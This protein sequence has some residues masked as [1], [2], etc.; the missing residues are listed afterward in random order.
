MKAKMSAASETWYTQAKGNVWLVLSTPTMTSRGKWRLF[1]LNVAS[2]SYMNSLTKRLA[3]SICS[4]EV[5]KMARNCDVRYLLSSLDAPMGQKC[6]TS[7][8]WCC[9]EFVE[10]F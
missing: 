7:S 6:T 2:N 9:R 5:K 3:R 4:L 10:S 1:V 8:T